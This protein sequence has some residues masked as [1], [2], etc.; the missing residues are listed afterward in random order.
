MKIIAVDDEKLML[1]MLVKNI[2]IV[3]PDAEIIKF[4]Y[5]DEALEYVKENEIDIAF[6]DIRMPGIDG[7]ELGKEILSL[8]PEVNLIYCSAYEEYLSEAFREVRCNG[9]ITKPADV[10]DIRKE[11]DNLRVP[12]K[13][14]ASNKIR[15]QCF[16]RFEVYL[17]GTP[18][19]FESSKTKELLAF[20]VYNSGGICSNQEIIS[21]LWD[22]EGRHD[23]YFKKIRKDLQ[24]TLTQQ[25]CE[26][27]LWRQWGGIGINMDMVDCDYYQWKKDNL[28]KYE[29]DFM[30]QYSWANTFKY[31]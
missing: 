26:D 27:I 20:L 1:D 7:L 3:R 24:D 28:G 6:L 29:G 30:I 18:L 31:E 25:G 21:A 5:S 2:S 17:N 15:I 9:Y 23:S 19:N 10:D 11:L 16:G 4:Q 8:Y 12:V 14:E 22:D 13:Q